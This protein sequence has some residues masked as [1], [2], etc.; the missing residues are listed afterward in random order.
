MVATNYSPSRLLPSVRR[1]VLEL[2]IIN[3]CVCYDFFCMYL[4]QLAAFYAFI[5][6]HL[7]YTHRI[8]DSVNFF[9]ISS[10]NISQLSL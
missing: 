5:I 4:A 2:F 6:L 9:F 7:D 8:L 1:S 10:Y 3:Q